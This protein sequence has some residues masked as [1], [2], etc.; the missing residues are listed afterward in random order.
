MR[1]SRETRATRTDLA[2]ELGVGAALV[3]PVGGIGDC[4]HCDGADDGASNLEAGS[5]R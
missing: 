4:A 1:R 5:K 3:V 2:A